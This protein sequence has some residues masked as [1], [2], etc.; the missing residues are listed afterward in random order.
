MEVKNDLIE[1][2][3]S[4][5]T[6]W[7]ILLFNLLFVFGIFFSFFDILGAEDSYRDKFVDFLI[8]ELASLICLNEVVSFSAFDDFLHR[9][10]FLKILHLIQVPL[11][12][13]VRHLN[14]L[15]Q[16]NL[17][18]C[19]VIDEL[20]EARFVEIESDCQVLLRLCAKSVP[21]I[22]VLL[23]LGV[24]DHMCYVIEEFSEA[25]PR[26]MA[27]VIHCELAIHCL[28]N[29]PKLLLKLL[30][31]FWGNYLQILFIFFHSIGIRGK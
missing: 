6:F 9:V 11:L 31:V 17:W 24:A 10:I 4:G 3:D 18:D 19:F 28:Q 15:V 29:L 30:R 20:Y 8:L 25:I 26:A 2:V 5:G 27:D 16:V 1:L 7:E 21:S 23:L 12:D 14:D 22:N 13:Q